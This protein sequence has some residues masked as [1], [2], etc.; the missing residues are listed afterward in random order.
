MTR[1]IIVNV[2]V[3]NCALSARQELALQGIIGVCPAACFVGNA[4]RV[5]SNEWLCEAFVYLVLQ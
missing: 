1:E 3:V 2:F 5:T 4:V